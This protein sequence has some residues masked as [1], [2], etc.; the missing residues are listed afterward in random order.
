VRQARAIPGLTKVQLVHLG[1]DELE[2]IIELIH[3][4]DVGYTQANSERWVTCRWVLLFLVVVDVISGPTVG[5][6]EGNEPTPEV[7]DVVV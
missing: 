2:V 4:D 7:D 5:G 1:L 6:V 3:V